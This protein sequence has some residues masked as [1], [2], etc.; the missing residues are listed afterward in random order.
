MA[1]DVKL[2]AEDYPAT[3]DIELKVTRVD[4]KMTVKP[5]LHERPGQELPKGRPTRSKRSPLFLITGKATQAEK[6]ILEDMNA[7]WWLKGT[8]TT[9]GRIR[10]YWG[11]NNGGTPYNCVLMDVNCWKESP[12]K[13]YEYI[14]ELAEV[15][16]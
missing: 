8:G 14:I 2:R 9:K 11:T 12:K 16:F 5:I 10:F 7:T 4:H 13:K 6:D 3:S 1:I 15:A